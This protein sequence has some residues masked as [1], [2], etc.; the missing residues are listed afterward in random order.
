VSRA[1]RRNNAALH[2]AL[3]TINDALVEN[4]SVTEI[5]AEL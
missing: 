3:R 4:V 1:G 2:G 5:K